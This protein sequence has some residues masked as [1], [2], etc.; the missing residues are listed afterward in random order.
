MEN[1]TRKPTARRQFLWLTVAILLT[2]LPSML[3]LP[4]TVSA[5]QSR[6]VPARGR[7]PRTRVA[8]STVARPTRA[9]L[10]RLAPLPPSVDPFLS[11]EQ[12]AEQGRTFEV[13]F[14][15]TALDK[16]AEATAQVS[17]NNGTLLV[18]MNAKNLPTP[19]LYQVP[20]YALWV[21]VP[22]Y[23]LKMYIG[24]LPVVPSSSATETV[25]ESRP[26]RSIEKP[27]R[28]IKKRVERGESISAYRF[29]TLPADAQ[30]GGLML[31]A[32]PIRYTSIVNEALRPVLVA[33]TNPEDTRVATA[34]AIYAGSFDYLRPRNPA[35][36]KIK[37]RVAPST[38]ASPRVK[39]RTTRRPARTNR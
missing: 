29:T 26:G 37:R 39:R 12:Q 24:D 5:Q 31:T 32:E 7:T 2:S 25:I 35:P 19:D 23:G 28:S 11:V 10:P 30:F 33:L 8:A 34:P 36:A 4:C 17:L 38:K 20:R 9:A 1:L 18:R 22:N 14:E 13:A 15:R 27:A 6:T 21:Y 3:F 16:K